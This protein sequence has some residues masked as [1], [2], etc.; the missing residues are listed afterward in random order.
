MFCPSCGKEIAENSPYCYFCG[1]R[2]QAA[3]RPANRRLTR[4]STDKMFAGVCGGIARYL[5]VDS[6]VV[7]ILWA[8]L[9]IVPGAIL[10]GIVVYLLAWLIMPEENPAQAAAARARRLMRSATDNKLA[11]VCGGIAQYLGVDS[12]L[13]RLVWVIL[14]VVPLAFVGG[15]LIYLIAWFVMPLAPRELPAASATAQNAPTT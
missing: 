15:I 5:G 13:V 2:Q 4:S 14:T 6:S 9:T 3:A 11:G 12:T 7:R 1:E 10:G 8:I